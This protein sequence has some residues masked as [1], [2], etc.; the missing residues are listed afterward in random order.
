GETHMRKGLLTT[1]AAAMALAIFAPITAKAET[2]SASGMIIIDENDG[3]GGIYVGQMAKDVDAKWGTNIVKDYGEDYTVLYVGEAT[4]TGTPAPDKTVKASELAADATVVVLKGT[5][6]SIGSSIIIKADNLGPV[7]ALGP[8]AA[9]GIDMYRLYNPNSGEHHYTKNAGEKDA[10]VKYGWNY[11]GIGWTAPK[12]GNPVY[13]LYNPNNGGDHHYTMN[14]GEK[15]FL[16]NNGWKYEGIGWYSDPDQKVPVYREYNPNAVARN[17]NYTANK[18][19]H[20]YLTS[21][22]WRDEGI[23]WYAIGGR[24]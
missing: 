19:E 3:A 5:N 7:I 21:I 11:E 9:D 6:I 24:K 10:L 20:N 22:G 17:H 4:V 13:R 16:A 2:P 23:G 1:A 15:N 12:S 14:A 8:V 18:G